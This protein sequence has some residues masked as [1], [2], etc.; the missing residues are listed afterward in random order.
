MRLLPI[1]ATALLAACAPASHSVPVD[2]AA[3]AIAMD[4]FRVNG[5]SMLAAHRGGPAAGYPENALTSQRR[6]S[7]LGVLYAEIN[8]RRSADGALFLLHDD[9]LDRTTSGSG[10]LTGLDWADLSVLQ[11][12][13][14]D[15]RLSDTGIPTLIDALDLAR[16][17]GLILNLDLKS[18]SP[19]EI[20]SFIHDH[21][22][23]DLVAIIAYTVDDAAAIHALDPGLLLSVPDERSALQQAGVNLAASYI[24]LGTG[25]IDGHVDSTLAELDLETSAGLFRRENGSVDLYLEARDANIELIAVDDV[26]TAVRA[27]GG[28]AVLL[29]QIN[30]CRP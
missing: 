29:D 25:A 2:R 28:S 22:A 10:P 7:E 19:E 27:L 15:G 5:S 4:C 11:L 23:R 14:N 3:P 6:L 13:D 12:H 9:T 26:D 17:T 21:D 20:V 18:V 1:A 8:V 24:W 30:A 16:N